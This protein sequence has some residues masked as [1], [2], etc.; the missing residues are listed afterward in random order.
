[1]T[2]NEFFDAVRSYCARLSGSISSYGRTPKHNA[3]VGG[4]SQ[5]AHQFWLGADVLYDAPVDAELARDTGRRLGLKVIRE[6]DHDHLQ[7]LDWST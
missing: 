7:P 2:A 4:V 3:K 6:S 1:M 5:S